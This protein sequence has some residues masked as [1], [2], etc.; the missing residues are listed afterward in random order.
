M[1]TIILTTAI[2]ITSINLF[3]QCAEDYSV[4]GG[5]L[6]LSWI[7]VSKPSGISSITFDGVNYVGTDNGANNWETTASTFV[8]LVDDTGSHSIDLNDG[9]GGILSAGTC[10]YTDGD[11]TGV[12]PIELITFFAKPVSEK[13]ELYWE[14]ASEKNNDYFVVEK[15]ADGK[16]FQSISNIK[17]AGSSTNIQSYNAIDNSPVNGVA[18]YRL[19]QIDYNGSFTYS[20]L[21]SVEIKTVVEGLVIYPNPSNGKEIGIS[22]NG[23]DDEQINVSIYDISGKQIESAVADKNIKT[24]YTQNQLQNGIYFVIANGKNTQM[25]SKLVVNY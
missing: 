21:V 2:L 13:V 7:H 17:G 10:Y 11:L 23:L 8:H 3:S 16:I 15:S 20:D 12:L 25:K 22:L 5:K 14:T 18:Y 24:Y 4:T 1:K 9:L 6:Q 19:K